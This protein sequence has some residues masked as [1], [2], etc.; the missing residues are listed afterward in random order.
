[1][2]L[3]TGRQYEIGNGSTLVFLGLREVPKGGS[4]S[5][6]QSP[7]HWVYF[8][9]NIE[10][11]TEPPP[12][13]RA[14][15]IQ[16]HHAQAIA[17]EMCPNEAEREHTL[18]LY[19][20]KMEGP[21]VI[22]R[23]RIKGYLRDRE[24]FIHAIADDLKKIW[25]IV[26]YAEY[27]AANGNKLLDSKTCPD[28]PIKP[29]HVRIFRQPPIMPP[30]PRNLILKCEA[31]V[32]LGFDT[33]EME[34]VAAGLLNASRTGSGWNSIN[35]PGSTTTS[36]TILDGIRMGWGMSQDELDTGLRNLIN[37]GY[38]GLGRGHHS[39]F[40]RESF[41]IRCWHASLRAHFPPR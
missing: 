33:Q 1:M 9:A 16:A 41:V 24:K 15:K 7:D 3:R 30:Q 34:N 31:D 36:L 29:F 12:E 19:P 18:I 13:N 27:G 17:I 10:C 5:Y 6:D 8:V 28:V 23:R 26:Y 14:F 22:F 4:E 32:P 35:N 11:E 38:V 39:Y 2:P 20:G 40:L 25:D 37:Q 21:R